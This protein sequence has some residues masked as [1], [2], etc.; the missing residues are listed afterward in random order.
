MSSLA[1]APPPRDPCRHRL[2]EASRLSL[3][4]ALLLGLGLGALACSSPSATVRPDPASAA[5]RTP[6]RPNLVLEVLPAPLYL[7][8]LLTLRGEV[9][10][11]Q[12]HLNIYNVGSRPVRLLA[13]D[14][15]LFRGGQPLMRQTL[16]PSLLAQELRGVPWIEIKDRQTFAAAHRWQGRHA[17]PLGHATVAA[18]EIVSV[19]RHLHLGPPPLWPDR[20]DCRVRHDQGIARISLPLRRHRTA[21]ILRLPMAGLATVLAGHRFDEIHGL[22][23][24]KSQN[25]AYDLAVLRERG[26]TYSGDDRQNESYACH[27][28]PVLAAADGLVALVH[29]GVPENTPV[30]KRPSWESLL[31]QPWDLAGNFVVIQHLADEHTAYLHLRPGLTLKPGA[32]IVA[33]EPVGYCGN[34]GNSREPHVHVQLMDGPDPL[35]ANGLPALFGD[36]TVHLGRLRLYVPAE[37]GAPLP[38]GSLVISGRSEGAIIPSGRMTE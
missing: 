11:V 22:D 25:F 30:G 28:Q 1:L 38:N 5:V 26:S 34:S 3:T 13:L 19:M 8:P 16:S 10:Q 2:K 4:T 29:D 27:G 24:M 36:F 23:Y 33:G 37:G 17:L 35:S 7:A 32:R 15:E 18:R 20:L 21:T 14:L 6:P 12:F 31:R 9:I